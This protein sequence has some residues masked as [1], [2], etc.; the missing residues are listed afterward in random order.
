LRPSRSTHIELALS[1]IL[2]KGIEWVLVTALS[3]RNAVI[4]VDLDDFATHAAGNFA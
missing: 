2:A 4:L 1:G 3:A